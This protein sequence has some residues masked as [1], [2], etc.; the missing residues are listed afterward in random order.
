MSVPPPYLP[1]WRPPRLDPKSTPS[2]QEETGKVAKQKRSSHSIIR[3]APALLMGLA[4]VACGAVSAAPQPAFAV[5]TFA[6]APLEGSPE[7][8]AIDIGRVTLETTY[9]VAPV[10]GSPEQT[11][12]DIGR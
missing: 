9:R 4:A 3:I 1:R 8:T 11:A 6:A 10:E 7:Q 2:Q 12:I 5:P